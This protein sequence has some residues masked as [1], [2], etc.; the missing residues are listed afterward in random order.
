METEATSAPPKHK[1]RWFQFSLR[2]LLI[3]TA[4]VA[5]GCCWLGYRIEQKRREREAVKAIEGTYGIV[6]YDYQTAERGGRKAAP[7]GPSWLR[8]ILGDN[9]FSE[10]TAVYLEGSEIG[11]VECASL[12][13]LPHLKMLYLC[14]PNLTDSGLARLTRLA[15]LEELRVRASKISDA[16]LE[17]IKEFPSLRRLYLNGSDVTDAGIGKLKRELPNCEMD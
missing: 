11:D 15:E 3:F 6:E 9:F 13:E 10:P 8:S 1:R 5:V 2:T 16:G 7:F 14:A 17:H 4:V 12:I